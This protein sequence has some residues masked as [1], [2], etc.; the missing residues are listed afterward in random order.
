MKKLVFAT[1]NKHKL[2]EIKQMLGDNFELVS[3][4]E[5]GCTEDVP[6]NQ[7][8]LEGNASQKSHFIYKKYGF[9]CFADDTGLEVEALNNAPGVYSARYA[10]PQRD[11]TDNINKLLF[12]LDKINCRKARFRTVI[13]LLINGNEIL[14]EGIVNGHILTHARG[15]KGFGYDPVFQ[16]DGYAVSF[17]EMNMEEKNRISHRGEAFRK[18]ITY[19]NNL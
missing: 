15:E 14:F 3:L 7:D 1:N 17:A 19:L 5:I 18:L 2:H 12:E 16:P 11:S 4:R 9:D 10:G 6:E 8:T 13:S